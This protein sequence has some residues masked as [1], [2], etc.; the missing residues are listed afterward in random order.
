MMNFKKMERKCRLNFLQRTR[1]TSMR[2][3]SFLAL[4]LI[5]CSLS[6]IAVAQD[7]NT[8]PFE[9][10]IPPDG[11]LAG[12]IYNM[13]L[14]LPDF[15]FDFDELPVQASNVTC[16]DLEIYSLS[17]F[18]AAQN[19]SEATGPYYELLTITLNAN[20]LNLT[21]FGDYSYQVFG[22]PSTGNMTMTMGNTTSLSII[23]DVFAT[24]GAVASPSVTPSISYS[25]STSA[26][27]SGTISETPSISLS[28]SES[29]S[30]S[31]SI[32]ESSSVSVSISESA[33]TSISAASV[34]PSPS[35][36]SSSSFV[37]SPTISASVSGVASPT[38]SASSNSTTGLNKINV[39][40]MLIDPMQLIAALPFGR[41]VLANHGM[42]KQVQE[43]DTDDPLPPP[44]LTTSLA[45]CSMIADITY[46]KTSDP[47]LNLDTG[48][49]IE[50]LVPAIPVVVCG[51]VQGIVN[52][53]LNAV[54]N[55]V[56]SA[57]WLGLE[58]VEEK[59][60]PEVFKSEG[61]FYSF[62]GLTLLWVVIVAFFAS[63][64]YIRTRY[65][66]RKYGEY[67]E[68][69][70]LTGSGLTASIKYTLPAESVPLIMHP[71]LNWFWKYSILLA[72]LWNIALFISA[73]ISVA[74]SVY[75]YITI[76]NS[77]TKLPAL[78]TFMLWDSVVEM[79][80]A[81]VWP[82]S[83]LIGVTSGVWPYIKLIAMLACWTLPPKI[84]SN[85]YRLYLLRVLDALG[86]WSL[87]DVY[88]LVLFLES[89][90]VHIQFTSAIQI[91]M[92]VTVQYAFYSYLAATMMSLILTH[93]FLYANHHLVEPHIPKT[94][95][96]MLCAHHFTMFGK[97]INLPLV[98]KIIVI[99]SL[100]ATAGF[101]VAGGMVDAFKFSWDGS[102]IGLLMKLSGE[103]TEETY[104][105]FS[106]VGAIPKTTFD[107]PN[108]VGIRVVQ[109][110][111][112]MFVFVIPIMHLLSLLLLWLVPL[113]AKMQHMFYAGV[114]IL[115]AWSAMDVFLV[116]LIVALVE[117]ETFADFI[118][119]RS[120]ATID[121]ILT[122]YLPDITG[123]TC[124]TVQAKL[125]SGV[126]I[127]AAGVLLVLVVGY[128]VM[129]LCNKALTER[130]SLERIKHNA[131]LAPQS[132]DYEDLFA[133]EYFPTKSTNTV[134]KK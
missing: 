101:G 117:L 123:G 114:E 45:N 42:L 108:N 73:N 69:D 15:V 132:T 126:W 87:I 39:G 100:F 95:Y 44:V 105:V 92:A 112:V 58:S 98:V 63:F 31:L 21:C 9:F 32:S 68:S 86:K 53:T 109:L 40:G 130:I 70:P 30:V 1:A 72:L 12:I 43:D 120:C 84:L 23:V 104:S 83:L 93:V 49:L 36:S 110:S 38:P 35:L 10:V 127:L 111:Y 7:S 115:N 17:G 122:Q 121:P 113:K 37:P 88:V 71:K 33:S 129:Y 22:P 77:I 62:L 82:L 99:L 46:L 78:Y 89:F 41:F 97:E 96:Q 74:S 85:K 2:G 29:S 128:T 3:V 119:S 103:A 14:H 11:L 55:S 133:E 91:D 28:I 131:K 80:D 125:E 67:A 64:P 54:L 52:V 107:D 90:R 75:L 106:L 51:Q 13:T 56:L 116:A 48:K 20:N 18:I 134:S 50:A 47:L 27:L 76:G 124:F 24:E 57:L 4:L 5:L 65:L 59:N 102:L 60:P 94:E 19:F 79:W 66:K 61:T 26:S 81:G 34:S 25:P 6:Q 16:I 8:L 118:A